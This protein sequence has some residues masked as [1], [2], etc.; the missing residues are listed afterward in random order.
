MTTPAASAAYFDQETV[1]GIAVALGPA[2]SA[3]V[4]DKFASE[5]PRLATAIEVALGGPDTR[6]LARAAHALL[7]TGRS[8]GCAGI[9]PYCERVRRLHEAGDASS[10][11]TAGRELLVAAQAAIAEFAALRARAGLLS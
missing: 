3:A 8:F 5:L 7:G 10:A 6:D 9:A 2:R 4:F 11:R 1:R